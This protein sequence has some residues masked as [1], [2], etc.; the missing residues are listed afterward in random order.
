M[1]LNQQ[2]LPTYV[3]GNQAFAFM[4]K[5]DVSKYFSGHMDNA[6]LNMWLEEDPAEN[7]KGMVTL[8]NQQTK[9]KPETFLDE[10]VDKKAVLEL[11]GWDG[12]FTYDIATE[13]RMGCYTEDD[14]SHQNF[15]GIDEGIFYIVLSKEYTAGTV[16]TYDDDEGYQI[17][18]VE[19]EEVEPTGTG[20]KHP[21]QLVTQDKRAYFPAEKLGK[22]IEYF[23]VSHSTGEYGTK[24]AKVEM[25]DTP[26]SMKFEFRLGS[27][28]GVESSVT[29]AAASKSID[30]GVVTASTE[31]YLDAIQ[32]EMADN[33]WGEFAVRMDLDRNGKPIRSTA[34]IGSTMEMLTH[35][36]L[37][38]LTNTK[39]LFQ[40]AAEFH[41]KNGVVRLNEGLWKQAK[42]GRTITYSRHI[43]RMHIQEAVE[44]VFRASRLR[45]ED[46]EITFECGTQAYYD[47]LNLFQDEVRAQ[48][49]QM[50][51]LIGSDS[52][53]PKSP[54]TGDSLTS[55]KL[56]ALMFEAVYLPMIGNVRIKLNQ[57]FDDGMRGDR[58]ATGM[59]PRGKAW[60]TYSMIIWDASSSKYS[61]NA[62]GLPSGTSLVD[63]GDMG[64]NIYL[65]KPQ[66]PMM[67]S[68]R[69]TG[70]FDTR[71][72]S[73]I[74]A[75]GKYMEESYFA[76][77]ILDVWL[78]DPTKIVMI[79]K[80][81]P[82]Y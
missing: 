6:S 24:F 37:W 36:Y 44:Y 16:L 31:K 26:P 43:T 27:V 76:Y 50:A 25:P 81:K 38:K 11:N 4:G 52:L 51:M 65:V 19:D 1:A 3:N 48:I 82:A 34:N 13:E 54:V 59:A 2:N 14:M 18:V 63:G 21:V 42:R 78:K 55:L 41:G 29:G 10:L 46:R 7:Y 30:R 57:A 61:N 8:W 47:V 28:Q 9:G 20:Y 49:P 68:G 58:F 75:S 39:L 15:A 12:S 33:G 60:T 72:S 74:M 66:G 62:E 67:Y 17:R 70:R 69:S 80:E 73:D 23:T 40:N 56:G 64:A 45:I 71:K 35:K 5:N 77:N 32:G 22:G 53:L 79:E